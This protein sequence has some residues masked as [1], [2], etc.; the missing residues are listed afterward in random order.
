MAIQSYIIMPIFRVTVITTKICCG[1]RIDK[2]LSVDVQTYTYANPIFSPEKEKVAQAFLFQRGVD[3]KKMNALNGGFL[4][5]T[6]I[7]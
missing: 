5:A 6:R 3:L 2:G 7:G 1:Q 4:K